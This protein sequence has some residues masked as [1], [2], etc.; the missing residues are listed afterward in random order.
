MFGCKGYV[1]LFFLYFLYRTCDGKYCNP[2]RKNA[3]PFWDHSSYTFLLYIRTLRRFRSTSI[4]SWPLLESAS[5][6]N[7]CEAAISC[8]S[9]SRQPAKLSAMAIWITS[10]LDPRSYYMYVYSSCPALDLY[11][12]VRLESCE[13]WTYISPALGAMLAVAFL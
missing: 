1:Q 2:K 9:S 4:N 6:H 7:T 3:R 8:P 10:A 12:A 11:S 5:C 13:Q